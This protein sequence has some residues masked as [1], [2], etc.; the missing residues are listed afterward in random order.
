[1]RR[2][3]LVTCAALALLTGWA[4]SE[5][6]GTG[7]EPGVV[8]IKLPPGGGAGSM[9]DLP[10]P[11]YPPIEKF[12]KG[13]R[14]IDGL[15]KLYQKDEHLYAEIKPPQLNRP[16]LCP[17]AIARGMGMGGFT[18]NFDEQWVLLF[19]KVSDTKLHLIRRNV[20]FHAQPG[21]PVAKAVEI[22]Y[23]DS[24][25]A[26]IPIRSM[27]PKTSGLL[28]DLADIFMTDFAQLS[29]GM[30]DRSRTTWHKVKA[31]PKNI[32]I[33][34]AATFAGGRGMFRGGDS[35]IDPRGTTVV[36]HYGLVELS[37]GGYQPRLADD[38]VGHFLSVTKD[39]SSDSKD[40]SFVRHVNRW[41]LERA[42]TDAKNKNKLSVPKKK[43]VFW[44]ENSVPYEYR[45]YVREGILE[46]NKA[47]AKVGFRDAIE[48][49]QQENEVFDPEDIN[50]NTFRWITTG[51][52][53]AMGPSRANPLT[54]EL[55]DA[56]IIFDADLIRMWKQEAKLFR[57]AGKSAEELPSL[58]RATRQGWDLL[59]T[60]QARGSLSWDDRHGLL[61]RK[62]E[63]GADPRAHL[64]ALRQGVCRCGSS[65]RHEL[66][67]MGLALILRGQ[68]GKAGD[69]IP[70]ELIGQAVKYVVMHEVGH[71]LGLR[72][73]FKASAMLKNEQ[74]HDT[75]LTRVKGLAGSVM[76][77][78]PVNLAPR[79]V[80]QGDYFMTTLGPY[81]YWAI[82]YAYKPLDGG[83]EG[84]WSK[85]QEIAR[86]GAEPGHDY[87]TDEDMF[88]TS[89]PHI[90]VWDLGADTMKF[91]MDRMLLSQE[92][93][94][95]LADKAVEKGE[96][97]QRVRQ[98]FGLLLGQYGN[99]AYLVASHVGGEFAH[100]DHR[101]DPKGRD[102]LVP[103]QAARQRKALEFL[104]NH[105][106]T[107]KYFQFPPQLL[108]RL[109]A[110]RW[111]HWG[112][113]GTFYS[114]VD[115]P[116]HGRVLGIQRV[117]LNHLLDPTVLNRIQNNALK[118]DA[119][120]NP[121]TVGEV[122][123]T[124]TDGIWNEHPIK[125]APAPKGVGKSNVIRRNLQ[126]EHVKE[127]SNL[128]LG[129]NGNG[130]GFMVVFGR[131]SGRVPP[132]AKSLARLHL[133]EIQGRIGNALGERGGAL[134]DT[135][136]AHLE[137][138]RERIGRVLNAS[139]QLNEP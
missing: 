134:D 44:I 64:A 43:I 29:I 6:T 2:F 123:R 127:L 50:Y 138:C 21:S 14:E 120:D 34:V 132:D 75:S 53:F 116:V 89:D 28:I 27:N 47:F 103:V 67:L 24:I 74:L 95:D 8:P 92:L 22:T 101:D 55:L 54:G 106:L 68:P 1:M 70:E 36:I 48:V 117:V 86:R 62:S 49:R 58:I 42:D 113:E 109:A 40:T 13:A 65:L 32:E 126:R 96:G 105:V 59:G 15:F 99:G 121:L 31:F 128:V 12:I 133:R 115:Y 25:L 112:N 61:V 26:A 37:E 87:G 77:Y 125:D 73:N 38:R 10:E 124:L 66:G 60:P 90:N 85:L 35:V 119:D 107:D 104:K 23:T 18:L 52:A 39:F 82:E 63:D 122:F 83:T 114:G 56:D 88:G 94:K 100:R 84:E 91:A 131:G 102:P 130:G 30:L 136:R 16:L 17:I 69:A 129:S 79:G 11:K 19:K 7:Q 118:T 4:G 51:G 108:R 93:M 5:R 71:T 46:W 80:K 78:L 111:S 57:A 98:A 20:R 139:L 9:P 41:R 135:A 137:E 33:Q 72:H 81:D 110:D 3:L 97:Y 45:A 76:D